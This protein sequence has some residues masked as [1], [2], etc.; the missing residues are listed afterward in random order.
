MTTRA[1]RPSIQLI[2]LL[3]AVAI[4]AAGANLLHPDRSRTREVLSP[5]DIGFAQDMGVH[6]QQAVTI[7][8]MLA[9]DAAPDVL[10]L[11][12][13]IRV[14]QLREMGI[15]TGWLQLAGQPLVSTAPMTWMHAGHPDPGM[16]MPGLATPQDLQRL[17]QSTGR[18]SETVFLQLMARHHQG[19]IEMA[20]Y[21]I[22]HTATPAVHDTAT[23]MVY[24]QTEE[25]QLIG[26]MLQQRDSAPLSYP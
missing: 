1:I 18:A 19:G 10:A 12:D 23:M 26:V 11:A 3:L 25:L 8:D 5:V 4:G 14:T 7:A 2:A 17:Q 6:H 22:A 21:A 20:A 16:P 9:P 15:M 13:Q 24:D